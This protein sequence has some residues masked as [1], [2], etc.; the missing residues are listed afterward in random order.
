VQLDITQEVSSVK[1]QADPT[2]TPTISQR[3]LSSSVTVEHGE[4]IVLGGLFSTQGTVGRAGLP[5]L[6]EL[7]LVGGAFGRT[8]DSTSRTELIVLISPKIV[9]DKF[10]AR[11][12]TNEMRRR[13]Q[14]LRFEDANVY[15]KPLPPPDV[16]V[17]TPV[18]AAP[19]VPVERL[20]CSVSC[21]GAVHAP[22][23]AG[24]TKDG[25]PLTTSSI[26]TSVPKAGSPRATVNAVK[27]VTPPKPIVPKAAKRPLPPATQELRTGV[28]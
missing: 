15:S 14:E 24:S 10:Q 9:G 18:A 26:G 11:H 21:D 13:I 20:D 19:V 4:T 23:T 16:I 17:E 22:P 8:S 1:R 5:V 12:A 2:L 6:S 27:P 3:K 25:A 7:P 28:Y